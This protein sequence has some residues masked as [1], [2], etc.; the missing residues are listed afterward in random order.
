MTDASRSGGVFDAAQ[1]ALLRRQYRALAPD[2][3]GFSA[4]FYQRLFTLAP[5]TR[6]LFRR[7]L[8]AQGDLFMAALGELVEALDSPTDFDAL[9]DRL[10]TAH[11]PH[12]L[13]Q[14]DADPVGRALM[15]ELASRL[16]ADFDAAAR[17]AWDRLY[18]TAV[19]P[20]MDPAEK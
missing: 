19:A 16:G 10:A 4:G 6:A 13:I 15:D 18:R 17:S 2:A 7:H 3:A 5:L 11:K 8:E 20:M 9:V 14:E 12:G 1:I